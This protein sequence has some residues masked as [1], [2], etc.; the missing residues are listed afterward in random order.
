MTTEP[1]RNHSSR[2]AVI[3]LPW[4][5][6]AGDRVQRSTVWLRRDRDDCGQGSDLDR[7]ERLVGGGLDRGDDAR[8]AGRRAE[9]H[10]GG[11][12]EIIPYRFWVM[13]RLQRVSIVRRPRR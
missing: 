5:P 6:P 10:V 2:R 7:P 1:I 12:A 4:Q 9:G 11:L 3:A 8:S 13:G